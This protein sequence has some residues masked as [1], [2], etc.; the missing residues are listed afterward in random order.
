MS[1]IAV[2]MYA[3][4][5]WFLFGAPDWLLLTAGLASGVVLLVLITSSRDSYK[6]LAERNGS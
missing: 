2:Y 1:A 4:F 6:V 5:A 3:L